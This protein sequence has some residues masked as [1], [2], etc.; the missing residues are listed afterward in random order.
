MLDSRPACSLD[1][2]IM[3]ETVS[4]RSTEQPPLAVLV[5][6][7]Q[8]GALRSAVR[9]AGGE[10]IVGA[11]PECH[12]VVTDDAVSRRHLRLT[13][14]PEGA[15]AEDL[16]SRNGTFF[17]GQRVGQLTLTLGSRLTLGKSELRIVADV[18]DFEGTQGQK[19]VSYGAL[20]GQAPSMQRLFTLLGRLEGSL[21]TV[22]IEGESGTGKEL[23]ARAIH[24]HSS[25]SKGPFIAINCGAL[26]RAL[27]KSELFG[28]KKGAFTGA[29]TD[30]IGAFEAADGGT[31]FLDEIGELELEVQ[32]VLLRALESGEFSRV[33]ETKTRK[34]RVRLLSATHQNLKDDV[35]DG[36]FREDLYYRLKVVTL[37]LPP[38]AA[39]TEDIPLL[40]RHLAEQAGYPPL[41]EAIALRL[42]HRAYPGNVRQLRHAID[43]WAAIGELP[44]ADTLPTSALDAVLAQLVDPKRP[45]AEQKELVVDAMTRA[46]LKKLIDSTG[47]NRSEAARIAELQRGYLRRLLEKYGLAGS[48]DAGGG[49]GEEA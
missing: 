8:G 39:R 20:R 17:L 33:G 37:S 43:A 21:A 34:S 45:Y 10:L 2:R 7:F 36:R 35:T 5:Q 13:L 44:E 40:A 42:A 38:L 28:H 11:A 47:G 25:V 26:D 3:T 46:Y 9:L 31:L 23:V 6:L 49:E 1:Q 16:G 12:L 4:L 14:A 27:V 15:L 19:R 22:L 48:G 30:S 24:D 41:P 18:A 32:P 29:V